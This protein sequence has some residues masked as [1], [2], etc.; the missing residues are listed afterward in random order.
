MAGL[1]RAGFEPESYENIKS[2]IEGKLEVFNAGFD[3]S[4][5]SPDGQ[6]IGIMSYELFQCWSQLSNVYNSY[7]PDFAT[8]AGLRNIGQ[9]SGLPYGVASRSSAV[10]EVTGT[11]GTVIPQGSIVLDAVGNEFYVAFDTTIPSNIQ[12]VAKVAGPT[13]VLAGTII[14]IQTPLAGWDTVSQPTS[15]SIGKL[16]QTEQEYRNDRNKSVMRNYTSTEET[17]QARLVELGLTQ[18]KVFNND[19]NAPIGSVPAFTIHVT[20]GEIGNVNENDIA[21]VIL[22]TKPLGCPTYGTSTRTVDDIMGVSHDVSFSKANEVVVDIELDVTFLDPND[23]GADIQI[24]NA[25]VE[26][27]NSLLSGE[28]VIWSRLFSFITPYAKAQINSLNIGVSGGA[29]TSTNLAIADDE[30]ASI[31]DANIT[32]TVT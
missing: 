31:S 17:M 2:R 18:A 4:P 14:A 9:L 23:A 16:A 19:T 12:V 24:T 3:F 26:H 11:A 10:C 29:L 20:V 32:I 15:G 5:E 21:K 25:L 30:F 6:L 13:P 1:S 22:E 27:I 8:G 7:N 28:D